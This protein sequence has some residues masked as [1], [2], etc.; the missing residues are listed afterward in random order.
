MNYAFVCF[1]RTFLCGFLKGWDATY[2]IWTQFNLSYLFQDDFF[3]SVG[4]Q[5]ET[6]FL[7]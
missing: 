4:F 2:K 3:F 7:V 5:G 6:G 1:L